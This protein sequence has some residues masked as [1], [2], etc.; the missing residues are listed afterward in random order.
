MSSYI[1]STFNY[2]WGVPTAPVPAPQA[3]V[4]P[5][6]CVPLPQPPKQAAKPIGFVAK[7]IEPEDWSRTFHTLFVKFMETHP[8][9]YPLVEHA[10]P[11]DRQSVLNVLYQ[12]AA[13]YSEYRE[14]DAISAKRQEELQQLASF[15]AFYKDKPLDLNGFDNRALML[16]LASKQWT[17][18]PH[19][20]TLK[21]TIRENL[22]AR[23]GERDP[24]RSYCTRTFIKGSTYQLF[25]KHF[26]CKTFT[27]EEKQA[28]C[29]F[30]DPPL[31]LDDA[32]EFALA[33]AFGEKNVRERIHQALLS[34]VSDPW[35]SEKGMLEIL[36]KYSDHRS[37]LCTRTRMHDPKTGLS[38]SYDSQEIW[39][40]TRLAVL[41]QDHPSLR[42]KMCAVL[43]KNSPSLV[44]LF[45][46]QK[47]A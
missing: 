37:S 3:A 43:A 5:K 40:I 27:E 10:N 38:H 28:L 17:G 29:E 16:M 46:M 13:S 31:L 23:R 30:V 44:P 22:I 1:R 8:L 36:L 25:F 15:M 41:C 45:Q 26:N 39:I 20:Q 6:K 34:F 4:P 14:V 47:G 19:E 35:V 12:S 7:G 9:S 21:A 2:F 33:E 11:Q 32:F 42:E 24:L 18:H